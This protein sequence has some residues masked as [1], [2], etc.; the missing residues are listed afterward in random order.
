MQAFVLD[1]V[2]PGPSDDLLG[3]VVTEEVKVDGRRLFRKGHR[4]AEEDL[5]AL[6]TVGRPLHAVRLG[7]EDVHEDE[8]GRRLAVA[9]GGPGVFP[10]GPVQSRVNLV[11]E[12]KGLLRVDAEAVAR[13]NRLP[14]IAV[15]TLP[16][17]MTVLPGKIVA[18][19]K[20]TP[21]A[22][23]E[24]TLVAAEGVAREGEAPVVR[25][26]PF[27][28]LCVGVLTTEGLEGRV[29]DR[30][31]ETVER[32]VGWYGARVLRFEDPP[33]APAPVAAA[34]EGL[35]DDGADLILTGGGNTIDPLDAALLALP[36]IGAEMVKFGAPAHPG[37]M[38]WL[39]HRAATD[40]PIFN[41]ASCS[42]YSK[43]TVADLVLPWVMAGERPT[44]DDLAGLGYGGL[45]DR[46]MG[47]RFPPY[48]AESVDEADEG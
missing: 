1:P 42:L 31:Q 29:R 10:R 18:G 47:F 21:V 26:K 36:R 8:A 25:V 14:G 3:A 16:D 20:I 12:T 17:R 43:A 32:K 27:R 9:V 44:L 2:Q 48:D 11:A 15:F 19:A 38:F 6:A 37:S 4:L 39:A 41:L 7:P 34:I 28:P 46:D 23:P 24:A 22:V 45:L 35:I 13:L 33:S 40:T 5:A 30:F